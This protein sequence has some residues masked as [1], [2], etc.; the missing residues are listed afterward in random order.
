MA[1]RHALHGTA[2]RVRYRAASNLV[3]HLLQELAERTVATDVLGAITVG[4]DLA[5]AAH[6]HVLLLL[7]AGES[8]VLGL[9][10]VLASRELHLSTAKSFDCE[11]GECGL[12]AHGKH[13]LANAHTG[14]ETTGLAIGSTHTS[15]Q[16]ISTCARKHLVD[17]EHLVRVCADAHVEGF[18]SCVLHHELVAGNT[19]GL[20]SLGRD[21]LAFVGNHV[22]AHR[23][24]INTGP[25]GTDLVDLDLGVR[26]TTAVA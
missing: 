21:L 14:N 7:V 2:Q 19:G 3:R 17:T 26:H 9:V 1:A 25:F 23:E 22:H 24:L 12:G 11:L 6:V 4:N 18:L 5:A 15:L 10:D 16:A 13:G 8:P 20:E